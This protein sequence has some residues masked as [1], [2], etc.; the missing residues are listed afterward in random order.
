MDTRLYR[1]TA[2]DWLPYYRKQGA[3]WCIVTIGMDWEAY[4]YAAL[5]AMVS[6]ICENERG[7]K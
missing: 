5:S 7:M 3:A 1:R 6:V 4:S 2:A